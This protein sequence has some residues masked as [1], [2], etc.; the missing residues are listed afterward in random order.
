VGVEADAHR[1]ALHRR[2]LPGGRKMLVYSGLALLPL[3]LFVL[4]LL[5]AHR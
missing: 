4:M 1:A 2:L 5:L 3:A